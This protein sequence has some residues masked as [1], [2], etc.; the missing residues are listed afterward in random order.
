MSWFFFLLWLQ[1]QDQWRLV[2]AD[3]PPEVAVGAPVAAAAHRAALRWAWVWSEG[4]APRRLARN[5]VATALPRLAAA[6]FRPD[7]ARLEVRVGGA[8]GPG[9]PADGWLIAGPLAMWADLGEEELPRWQLR[10]GG[11]VSIPVV[12]G[13][14]WRVRWA[15]SSGAGSWWAD[16]PAGAR[17]VALAGV[18]TPG[19][20]LTV[21]GAD[22]RPIE[23]I[24]GAV[25]EGVGRGGIPRLWEVLHGAHGR[26]VLPG[27]P[28][29]EEVT[30]V[31][32]ATGTAAAVLRGRPSDLPHEV[33]LTPGASLGGRLLGHERRPLTGAEVASEGWLAPSLPRLVVRRTRTAADGSFRLEDLPPGKVVLTAR[34]SGYVPL[35][36]PVELAAGRNDLG[37]RTLEPGGT[38]GVRVVDDRDQDVAG[39]E[40]QAGA[41]LRAVTDAEGRATLAGVPAAPVTVAAS[42]QHYLGQRALVN[43]PFPEWTRLELPRSFTVAGR[44]VQGEAT[45]VADGTVRIVQ[46]SRFSEQALGQDGRFAVDLPPGKS[47]ELV[48]RSPST[49]PLRVPVAEGAAGELRDLGDLAVAP[50]RTV[51][52]RVVRAAGGEPVA[53]ARVWLPRPGPDG[54]VLA[55]ASRDL[56]EAASGADGRFRLAGLGAGPA[57]LRIEAD[58]MARAHVAVADTGEGEMGA[59]DLGDI[60]VGLGSTL[61]ILVPPPRPDRGASLDSGEENEAAVARLDLRNGW[62]DPDMLTAPVT[63][64]EAIFRHIPP[65]TATATVL[66]GRRL[67]CEQRVEVPADGAG[68]DVDCRRPALRLAGRVLVGGV[69]AGAGVLVWEPPPLD[70]PGRID[71]TVSPGGL[72]QQQVCG[73]GRP[74]VDVAVAAD[75]TFVSDDLAPGHWQVLWSPQG[76]SLTGSL[77][78]DLPA[79]EAFETTLSFPGLAVAGVTTGEHDEPLA[80]ARVLELVSGALAIS[81]ADGAFVLSGVKPGKIAVRAELGELSSPLAELVLAPDRPPEPVRLVLAKQPSPKIVIEVVT[82]QGA[83]VAGAVVF[84]EEDGKGQRLLTTDAQG[85]A[86]ATLEAPLPGQMRAAA[87]TPTGWALGGWTSLDVARAGIT[88]AGSAVGS[89]VLLSERPGEVRIVSQ[90]GWDLGWLLRQLGAPPLVEA[91]APLPIGGLPA[92]TYRI[93]RGAASVNV[94]VEAGGAVEVRVP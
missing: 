58:G 76:G 55:W 43:P 30:V 24:G 73:V 9:P 80:E 87:Y 41:G 91:K 72:K 63:G 56:L 31:L 20:A 84:L 17:S 10:A 62:L 21:L 35:R 45:P 26:I 89:L 18:A 51:T 40:V 28:D 12:P 88:L 29:R 38:L 3:G 16:V 4:H 70:V 11:R 46:G 7:A 57:L 32:A 8:S 50:G 36:E 74:Q 19:I 78:V 27:L 13:E 47:A 2:Y 23:T 14:P 93:A 1:T 52:G 60:A 68:L 64:G 22:G 42:A 49:R 86:K 77:A 71:T 67:V 92:G 66:H 54:P 25:F 59:T 83:P 85:R 82:A 94:M 75:G 44:L 15:S 5:Q 34:A 79:V 81:G 6:R 65:G 33:R 37:A 53:G 69:A 39:A 48:L 90:D 61:R